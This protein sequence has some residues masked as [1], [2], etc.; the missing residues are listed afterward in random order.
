LLE[1]HNNSLKKR[2][3]VVE[4]RRC[5]RMWGLTPDWVAIPSVHRLYVLCIKGIEEVSYFLFFELV[6]DWDGFVVRNYIIFSW[7]YCDAI[8]LNL[9]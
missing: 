2:R 1:M 6:G 5:V 7:H 9:F 4:P 3:W 8:L